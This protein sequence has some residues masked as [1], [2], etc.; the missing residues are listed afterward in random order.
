MKSS[1]EKTSTTT[2]TTATQLAEKP[3][4][5]KAGGGDFFKPSGEKAP[6]V[7]AKMTVNKPGDKFEQEAD[8]MADKVMRME[9]SGKDEKIQRTP[10]EKIQRRE[11]DRIMRKEELQKAEQDKVQKKEDEKIQCKGGEGASAVAGQTR[12][13]IQSQANGGQSM[14]A[15]TRS[16][17]ESRLGA[18]FGNVRIHSDPE[19]ASLSNQLSARAFTYQ[20]HIFFSRDQYQPGTSEGKHLLAHELTHT[21][22]QGYSEQHSPK[23]STAAATPT[24][25][26]LGTQ[27]VLDYFADKA[28]H[29]PGFRLLTVVLGINPI[30]MRSESRSAS[31]I[32][33]GLIEVIPGGHFISQALDNHGVFNKAGAWVEQ[34]IDMLGDIGSDIISGLKRFI[35]SLSWTDILD[36]GG[37][38]NRAKRIFTDPIKRLID[39]GASVAVGLLKMVKDAILKPL[40]ALAQ[41]TRGY[42]LLKAVLGEDPISGESAPRNADTLIA[43]FMRLIGQEEVWENIKKGNAIA[44]AWTWFQGA[45]AGLMGMV[46]AIPRKIMDT[47]TSL[48]F[49]DIITVAGAFTKIVGA[50][51][52]IALDFISWGVNQVSSLLEILFSVVAP[53]AVPYISKAKSAFKKIIQDPIG[54]V[55]NLVRAGKLGF[56]S[57]A[58]NILNHLKNALVK[59]ITGP[60]GEAGVYI[61]QSFSLIE[62]IKLVLSVLGLTWQN[63]RAKLVKIIPEPVLTGLEKTAGILVTLVKDGPVAAWEQIKAELSELKVQLIAQITQMINSEIVQAAVMKLVSMLNPAGAFVQAIIAIYNTITFF[64]EK[65]NQIA[66]VVNSFID[67]IAAIAAGQV[68][69]AAGRVEQTMANTLTVVIAFLAK[70]AGLGGIPAKVT[71]IIRKIRQPIDKGLDKIVAWLGGMLK[72]MGDKDK[73]DARTEAQKKADLDAAIRDAEALLSAADA[74]LERIRQQ[75]PALKSKYKLTALELVT[76]GG[77]TEDASV[78]VHGAINPTKNSKKK[79]KKKGT[80]GPLGITRKSLSFA[81][82]TKT[83]LIAKFRSRFPAGQLGQFTEA[84]LDI[85]H[86]VSISDTINHL[87]AALSPL[88]VDEAAKV[89]EGKGYKPTSKGRSGIIAAAR[90]L[91]QAANN[92]VNNLFVGASGKNR[93]KGKRYDAGDARGVSATDKKFDP[94]KSSFISAFGIEGVDFNVTIDV[95]SD[96]V[97]VETWEITA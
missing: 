6:A 92:D 42:D 24:V 35:D 41:G 20:N 27:D 69:A 76:E 97:Q 34:E 66:A 78:Y 21:I 28:Y 43:G 10:E 5:E 95:T 67:S 32:L 80:V 11:D 89:L 53:G 81:A 9:A 31:N 75:L 17:M 61:P 63:I 7:Q 4:F 18:D 36:L 83:Y 51:A 33:R 85:R 56:Q 88:T 91:L 13:A 29:I 54:F 71:G 84:G 38:W 1:A 44:R 3:F 22:Q 19:A 94:Q 40:A 2:S 55:G 46:R 58:N 64:I 79:K 45:L 50:F 37:V 77:D 47:I 93:R 39:F 15:E 59:W 73:K 16:F 82:A 96:G 8:K 23:V 62:I 52:N 14:G 74:D 87:N 25:Q 86:K 12:S 60:L 90:E 72:K 30:N 26:R 65:I 70:F 68:T 49:Q 57:F 48:T